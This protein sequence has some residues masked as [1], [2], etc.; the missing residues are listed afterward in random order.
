MI[1]QNIKSIGIEL[2]GGIDKEDLENLKKYCEKNNLSEH[3]LF[4]D[5]GSVVVKNKEI[6]NIEI[7]FWHFNLQT[8]LK[9]VEYVFTKCCFEQNSTCGNHMHFKFIN[10]N[11]AISIFSFR[12]TWKTFKQ[13]YIKFVN[14]LEENLRE[15]YLKR[16][17]N[18]YC[19]FEYIT[20]I[21]IKQLNSYDKNYSRYYAINLSSYNLH[22]TLE[23][24]L[25]PHFDNY[26]EAEKAIL[27]LIRT[28]DKIYNITKC[29]LST[30]TIKL[31]LNENNNNTF[32]YT[33]KQQN[34][35]ETN[36]KIKVIKL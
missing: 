7:K 28:I 31:N 15:K 9:F 33:I 34:I 17:E 18:K 24:R 14:T 29:T 32:N 6:R 35:N 5:D 10:D 21:V 1:T 26:E 27:W 36:I 19:K 25:L 11:K 12:K 2:E 20:D 30:K 3:V 23:I 16:L 22:K 13:E 4:G 8:F